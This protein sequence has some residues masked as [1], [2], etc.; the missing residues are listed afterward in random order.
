ME[1]GSPNGGSSLILSRRFRP[2]VTAST[3]ASAPAERG[4]AVWA[5]LTD[6][7]LRVQTAI[8]GE[9]C[10]HNRILPT[11]LVGLADGDLWGEVVEDGVVPPVSR[12]PAQ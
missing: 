11:R 10:L 12:R 4:A 2:T 8:A 7:Y 3:V 6:N 5:G 1:T 9:A